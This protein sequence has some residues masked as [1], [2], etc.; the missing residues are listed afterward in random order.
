MVENGDTVQIDRADWLLMERRLETA[1]RLH[2][3]MVAMEQLRMSFVRGS[4][5]RP[6]V[7]SLKIVPSKDGGGVFLAIVKGFDE[8]GYRVGFH[9]GLGFRAT[10]VELG[11]RMGNA[12]IKF[13]ED[14]W[15]PEKMPVVFSN[16]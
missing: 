9:T 2:H 10:L 16:Q 11:R 14:A 3:E 15:P 1:D 5:E 4:P 6:L 12:S 8:G 13:K 7:Y